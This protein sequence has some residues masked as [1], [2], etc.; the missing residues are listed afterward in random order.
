MRKI[1]DLSGSTNRNRT[2]ERFERLTQRRFSRETCWKRIFK[3]E[4]EIWVEKLSMILVKCE[5]VELIDF[6][7]I[8]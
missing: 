6:V 7:I 8:S 4:L 2:T 5:R 1:R 3:Q